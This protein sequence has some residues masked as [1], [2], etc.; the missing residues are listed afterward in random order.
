MDVYYRNDSM[1]SGVAVS[2]VRLHS[3]KV[4]VCKATVGVILGYSQSRVK[5]RKDGW[6]AQGRIYTCSARRPGG[7]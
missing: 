6:A 5:E 3:P 2:L 4:A 7:R 1:K